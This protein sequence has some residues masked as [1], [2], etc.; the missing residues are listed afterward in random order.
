M[1]KPIQQIRI[2][3]SSPS[4]VKAERESAKR[5]IEELN[6][7]ICPP[8]GLTLFP[9][10]WEN[11]T[12]SAVGEYS[13]DVINQQIGEYDIFVGI[14]ANRFGTPT[15]NA[16]SGTEEEF[17]IAYE[18]RTNTQ[19][20]FFFKDAPINPSSLDLSQLDKVRK[21]KEKIGNKGVYYFQFPEDFERIFRE[22][23]TMHLSNNYFSKKIDKDAKVFTK[24]K[25]LKIGFEVFFNSK[26]SSYEKY[27][28][29]NTLAIPNSQFKL[30]DIYVAQTL[31]KDNRFEK[32]KE[33]TKIDQLP[34]ELIRKYQKILIK[35]T[36]GMGKST[37]MKYMFIDLIDNRIEDVGI[38]I[39]IE[40]NRLNKER[41]I[42]KEI[43][44]KLQFLS[45]KCNEGS[46]LK[47]IKE[48]IF[49]FFLDGYDEISIADR[50]EVT[51][52]IKDFIINAGTKN[53]YILTSRPEDS[54]ECFGD[55][56][57]FKIRPLTKNE[58]FELLTKYDITKNKIASEELIKELQT[59]KYDTI[60]EYLKN[61]LLVS[62]LYCAF[63]YKAEIPLK[64][65]QFYRQVYD[66]LFNSHKLAQ[67]QKP[68]EKRSGLDIDD[69]NRV[70][71][72]V[73]YDCLIN[74]GVQF[75]KD[76]ILN[77]IKKARVFS[78]N[79][80]FGESN[81]LKDLLTSVP[82]FTKDGTEYKW[83]HK[84]LMEYF[85]ARFIA[86][87]A[88]E[89]QNTIL[90]NIYN[91]ENNDK[92]FNMLDIYYD[93]DYKGFS[94]NITLPFLKSFVQFYEDN[95]FNS[96]IILKKSIER[97]IS[98][99]FVINAAFRISEKILDYEEEV[100]FF[101][102]RLRWSRNRTFLGFFKIRYK[103]GKY[104]YIKIGCNITNKFNLYYLL[105]KK[106]ISIFNFNDRDSWDQISA[107][108]A[109]KESSGF[110]NKTCVIDLRTGDYSESFYN[111]INDKL[112]LG[113]SSLN[114]MDC[115]DLIEK[116]EE[117]IAHSKDLI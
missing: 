63:N 53:Y 16:G 67:G 61:P 1:T 102:K 89:K 76:T 87:D 48:G 112:F 3:I 84:S 73:G 103:E 45:K 100:E 78:G 59:G 12:Y 92:Y 4:D 62:L 96:P 38:P 94:I 46:L 15:P 17:N 110:E 32:E 95:I 30:K 80:I 31:E 2:F 88:K 36:A 9:L 41:T 37:I 65:H 69:F 8:N 106:I 22:H 105:R 109:P 7:T 49:I 44:D 114:Y 93:I 43:Q 40:L 79:L 86:E 39:Y 108:N 99:L 21:F 66:A 91:S 6:R 34:V 26:N 113:Q 75:D 111:A 27:S 58:A 28:S 60:D 20:M 23:L 52:D 25:Q 104:S 74:L 10:T 13:Q 68:H 33:T 35:D 101:A 5:V 77:S 70:L 50:N 98:Y 81:F 54:V 24:T 64:K 55:F 47:L 117:E 57:S 97:R 42:L 85:A 115:K 18:N 83:S 90:T 11:N 14:M 71:R 82:L 29:I 72:Y 116:M 56:Q 51:Q 107:Y 19:I